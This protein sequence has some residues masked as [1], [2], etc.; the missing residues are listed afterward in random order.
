MRAL[1]FWTTLYATC[2]TVALVVTSGLP[3]ALG[4][5]LPVLLAAAGAA[6]LARRQTPTTRRAVGIAVAGVLMAGAATGIIGHNHDLA[7]K[8]V[9]SLG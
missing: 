1:A 8:T 2:V 9:A 3:E 5:C 4:F 7:R 6:W